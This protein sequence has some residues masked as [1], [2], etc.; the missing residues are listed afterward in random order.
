M[1]KVGHIVAPTIYEMLYPY[2]RGEV[3]GLLTQAL[4]A[5]DSFDIFHERL[6]RQFI[7]AR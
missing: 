4:T 2:C 7:P 1:S 3:L 6:L 5:G